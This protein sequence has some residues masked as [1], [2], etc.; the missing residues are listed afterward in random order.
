MFVDALLLLLHERMTEVRGSWSG[1]RCASIS[2][3]MCSQSDDISI[4]FEMN[5]LC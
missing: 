5:R 4:Y 1:G 3:F 2:A